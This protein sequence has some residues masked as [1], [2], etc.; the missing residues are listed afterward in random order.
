[1]FYL[2][3]VLSDCAVVS[4]FIIPPFIIILGPILLYSLGRIAGEST[5][6]RERPWCVHDNAFPF[7]PPSPFFLC[8][9]VGSF[10]RLLF[11][12]FDEPSLYL[13]RTTSAVPLALGKSIPDEQQLVHKLEDK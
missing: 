12:S 2:S 9:L 7:I 5:T 8:V 10:V 6:E 3:L 11:V 13:C 4:L 1:M